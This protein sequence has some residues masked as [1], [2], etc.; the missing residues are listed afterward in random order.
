MSETN[1]RRLRRV[2]ERV[3]KKRWEIVLLTELRADEGEMVSLGE[4]E[5]RAVLIHGRKAGVRLEGKALEAWM[6]EGKQR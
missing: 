5:E 1:V 3:T 4:E 2:A 6:E